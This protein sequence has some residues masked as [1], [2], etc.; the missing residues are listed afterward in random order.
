M[1]IKQLNGGYVAAEDRILLRVSTDAR[2]EFRFW[3][4]RPITAQ[5][6]AAIHAALDSR[7]AEENARKSAADLRVEMARHRYPT[8]ADLGS[9][10]QAA[11]ID[12]PTYHQRILELGCG[13]GEAAID[14]ARHGATVIAVDESA[15]AI[16]S[17]RA[18][19]PA[20]IWIG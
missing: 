3:L 11:L 19:S 12:W 15:T 6:R 14:F 13:A 9:W 2:E 18:S 16:S 7:I 8:L 17:A 10:L 5:L 20:P 1:G 4:T